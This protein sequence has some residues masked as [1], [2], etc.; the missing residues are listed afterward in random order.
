MGGGSSKNPIVL[1]EEEDKD[2]SPSRTQ[3]SERPTEPPRLLKSRPFG[4]RIE[5]VP[6]FFYRT[7]FE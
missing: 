3:A 2:D 7:L 6:E 1:D 5:N 4:R